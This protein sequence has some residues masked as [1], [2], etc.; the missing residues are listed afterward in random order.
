MAFYRKSGKQNVREIA[1]AS[2]TTL[3][4]GDAVKTNGS[5]ANVTSAT[6]DAAWLGI[7]LDAGASA[8]TARLSI[9]ILEPGV[10]IVGKVEAGTPTNGDWGKCDFNT[11]DG[12]TLTNANG[13]FLYQYV[14]EYDGATYSVDLLPKRLECTEDT[15]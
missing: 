12:V 8:S 11:L 10:W 13:D 7:C 14:G 6:S 9:D 15:G 4:K 1:K 5:S 2:G 3:A